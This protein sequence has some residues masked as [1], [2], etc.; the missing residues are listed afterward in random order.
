MAD[1]KVASAA[2]AFEPMRKR[3][4]PQGSGGIRTET[5]N[6]SIRA[7][8][9]ALINIASKPSW[10]KVPEW[11][12]DASDY[13]EWDGPLGYIPP[14]MAA[15]NKYSELLLL[16]IRLARYDQPIDVQSAVP[17]RELLIHLHTRFE[18]FPEYW[19][20]RKNRAGLSATVPSPQQ[21]GGD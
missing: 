2:T 10:P 17:L 15:L 18:I 8:V 19:P 20:A 6:F 14:D 16:L 21:T 12:W 3:G 5:V 4:R 13:R 11:G 1:S 9:D 7:T